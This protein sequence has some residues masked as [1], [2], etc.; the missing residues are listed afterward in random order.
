MTNVAMKPRREICSDVGP[1]VDAT[2][3]ERELTQLSR[4]HGIGIGG[5]ATLFVMETDDFERNYST[6]NQSHLQFT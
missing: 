1:A 2:A 4:K 5:S 6:D 3:F